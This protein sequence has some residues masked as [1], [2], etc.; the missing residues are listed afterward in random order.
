MV[1]I[2]VGGLETGAESGDL[3]LLPFLV[4]SCEEYFEGGPDFICK[5]LVAPNLA[6]VEEQASLKYEQVGDG[7]NL[8]RGVRLLACCRIFDRIFDLIR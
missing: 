7:D 6:V 3:R 8:L 2:G 5:V 4:E 1:D